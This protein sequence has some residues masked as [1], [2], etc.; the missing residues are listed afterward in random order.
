MAFALRR[1]PR[2]RSPAREAG[3][4]V[5]L[6]LTLLVALLAATPAQARQAVAVEPRWPAGA[7][8]IRQSERKLYFVAAP[9]L[10]IRYPVGVGKAGKAWFGAARIDGKYVEPAWSPPREVKRDLP[11][12]P[13]VIPGGSPKNPMGARA[14]TLDRGQYAIHGTTREMRRSVGGAV[15]YGCI[16]MLNEDVIDLYDR[17]AVGAPVIVIP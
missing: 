7:I 9:G 4:I 8:V 17:V 11:H 14:L 3:L 6:A 13:D 16:R 2:R 1:L 12:L 5:A 15:S 10:A